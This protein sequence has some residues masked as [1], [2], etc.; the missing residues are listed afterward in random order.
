M[1]WDLE[2]PLEKACK[3]ELLDFEHPEG[4]Q[5]LCFWAVEK[6]SSRVKQG[7][8]SSG[9][10]LHM[11]LEKPL[12]DIMVAIC[13]LVLL[14]RMDFSTRWLLR[15]GGYCDYYLIIY[16]HSNGPFRPVTNADYPA[17]E[18]VSESAIK[19]KQKFERLVVS[20]E[21]LL[22]MFNVCQLE[23]FKMNYSADI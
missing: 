22:E 14:L 10:P 16:Y 23:F 21:K 7:K 18:K 6:K 15:N 1:L 8:K 12:K 3:L 17:L 19:E 20:K 2:R 5:D 11:F 9:I 4:T 13:A